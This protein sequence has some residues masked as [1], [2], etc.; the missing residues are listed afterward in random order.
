MDAADSPNGTCW[1]IGRH[2]W[3]F[4]SYK[5]SV[6]SALALRCRSPLVRYIWSWRK[7]TFAGSPSTQVIDLAGRTGIPGLR[8]RR[9]R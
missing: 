5:T 2:S 6:M 3:G 8:D 1:T 4:F 7:R 9:R